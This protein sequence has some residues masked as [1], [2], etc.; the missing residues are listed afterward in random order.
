MKQL[1]VFSIFFSLILFADHS[2]FAQSPTHKTIQTNSAVTTS[3]PDIP[4]DELEVMLI[5]MT[6]DELLVEADSWLALLKETATKIATE[7]LE[8]KQKNRL[9]EKKEEAAATSTNKGLEEKAENAV[10]EATEDKVA[11][12]ADMNTLQVLKIARVDRL[13]A[14][15]RA[16]TQKT[17]LAEGG[18][19]PEQVMP[20]RLYIKA[21]SGIQVDT[22]DLYAAWV[23]VYG[24]L[25]SSEGG[26]RWLVNILKFTIIL[27]VFWGLSKVIG[28]TAQ[29]VLTISPSNSSILNNFIIN[30]SRRLT[31]FI[32]ILVGLSAL[33]I[34]IGP[35]IAVIGAA[36][37][38]VAFALQ[39]TLSNFASGIMI[40]FYRPFDVGDLIDVSGEYGIVESMTLV[41]TSVMTLDNKL[42]IVPNNDIWG[43]T[44]TNAT[45][46]I[47]RRV[48]MVFGIGYSDNI[49]QARQVMDKILADHP[50]VLPDPEPVVRLH[51]LGDSSVNFIC[52]P[53]AK[54]ADYWDVYWDVT[55]QVKECFDAEGISIPFPQRDIHIYNEEA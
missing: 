9:I 21:I 3:N 13:N 49:E 50:K 25:L 5:P 47:V 26:M 52:R 20:Y 11:L 7:Q 35:L 51:E 15:L 34:N 2:G 38:V 48:D 14:V 42:M 12:L 39:G 40:M 24:W 18:K 17:G 46:S 27:F 44:I 4:L 37:F 43:K 32:G 16:I 22:T 53:W 41:S 1:F 6:S 23:N 19:E 33:E 28:R 31:F 54:T 36:S 10:E 8:I 45:K 29:K 30:S 55:R